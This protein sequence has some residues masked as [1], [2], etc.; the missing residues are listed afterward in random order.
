MTY[1]QVPLE[2]SKQ[3]DGLW[4]VEAPSLQGCW[5]DADTLEEGLSDVQEVIAMTIDI[6]QEKEWALPEEVLSSDT[7]PLKAFVPVAINEHKF[8]RVSKIVKRKANR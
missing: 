1:Y 8:R 4:R 5:V 3:E 7:L 6:Y 2:I